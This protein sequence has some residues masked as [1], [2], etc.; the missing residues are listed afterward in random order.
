MASLSSQQPPQREATPQ[1]AP[2]W[3]VRSAHQKASGFFRG[4]AKT[5]APARVA[6]VGARVEHPSFLSEASAAEAPQ[7]AREW[8]GRRKRRRY[9]GALRA[10]KS[11]RL[12]SWG[13]YDLRASADRKS[14]GRSRAS[15]VSIGGQGRW[16]A[17]SG[18]GVSGASRRRTH[19]N[20]WRVE[21]LE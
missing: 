9:G 10:P 15:R 18:A 17:A 11:L 20:L 3:R 5:P 12:F 16:G 13:S 8:P 14:G 21:S 4:A 1:A 7:A 6:R 19:G 2:I